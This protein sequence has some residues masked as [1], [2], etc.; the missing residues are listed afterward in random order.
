MAS[1][2]RSAQPL[3]LLAFIGWQVRELW[4]AALIGAVVAGLLIWATENANG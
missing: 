3:A 2:G 4:P 1:S